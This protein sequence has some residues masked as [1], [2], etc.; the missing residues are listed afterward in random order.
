[1]SIVEDF[2]ALFPVVH[3]SELCPVQII[4]FLPRINLMSIQYAGEKVRL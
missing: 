2:F 3:D 4:V 1:M